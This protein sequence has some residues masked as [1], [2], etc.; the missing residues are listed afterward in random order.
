MVKVHAKSQRNAGKKSLS[1]AKVAFGVATAIFAPCVLAISGLNIYMRASCA[2]FYDQ[3]K[4]EFDNPGLAHGFIPQD[5]D[6]VESAD[7]WIF[8]GYKS[9]DASPLMVIDPH[10]KT[11]SVYIEEPDGETYRGHGGGVSS[12]DD[13]VYLTTDHGYLVIPLAAVINAADGQTVKAVHRQSL[14]LDP[15]FLNIQDG[16]LYTGVFYREGPYSTPPEMHITTPDGTENA[17][18]MFGYPAD[19]N[20]EYGFA[21]K[22]DR[23]YSIP[24]QAQGFCITPEG[25]GMFSTSWGA[26]PSGYLYYDMDKLTQDGTYKADGEEVPLY[27]FDGRSFVRELQ[28]P[29]MGEGIDVHD[30]RVYISNE[31][32]SNKYIFGKF[33]GGQ[34]VYSLPG[35]PK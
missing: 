31:S 35:D 21:T 30:G 1:P 6:Y 13:F 14:D 7:E 32:A 20:A 2:H 29:P 4:V 16:V 10:G 12:T 28:G 25:Q 5:L 24:G 9:Y 15:A 23:V 27:C 18:V 26:N 8:S 17:A 34:A 33:M 19:P 3:A 22:A 11:K